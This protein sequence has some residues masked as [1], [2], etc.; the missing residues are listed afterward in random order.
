VAGKEPPL[1]SAEKHML[2]SVN[3][4]NVD[5]KCL[6][7]CTFRFFIVSSSPKKKKEKENGT[8]NTSKPLNFLAWWW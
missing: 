3:A 5:L 1:S 2:C 7:L 8:K 6:Q 4:L